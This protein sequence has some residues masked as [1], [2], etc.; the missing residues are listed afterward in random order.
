MGTRRDEDDI[1]FGAENQA[2]G[3]GDVA[4]ERL[5][6]LHMIDCRRAHAVGSSRD[7]DACAVVEA[8]VVREVDQAVL[9]VRPERA[10]GEIEVVHCFVAVIGAGL[11][12]KTVSR[13]F[14]RRPNPTTRLR[15]R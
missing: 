3:L 7:L 13:R 4:A 15:A 6:D 9:H 11:D 8:I 14:Q 10:Q 5:W 12:H 1:E 2:D